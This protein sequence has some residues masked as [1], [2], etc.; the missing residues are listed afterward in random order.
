MYEKATG[1][2]RFLL[3]PEATGCRGRGESRLRAVE[4]I[5]AFSGHRNRAMVERYIVRNA[6]RQAK[7]VDRRDEYLVR[8]LSKKNAE[9]SQRISEVRTISR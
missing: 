8:R 6:D 3:C 2:K 7:S 9:D 5:M 1:F 4:E